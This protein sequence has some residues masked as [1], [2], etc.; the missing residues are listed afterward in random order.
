VLDDVPG[1]LFLLV[2]SGPETMRIRKLIHFLRLDD[3]VRLMG[4]VPYSEV[5]R[6]YPISDIFCI[7]SL[8]EGTCMV[9]EEAAAARLPVVATDFAGANDLIRNGENGF[10]VPVG[11]A[12]AVAERVAW[13]LQHESERIR[14]GEANHRMVEENFSRAAALKKCEEMFRRVTPVPGSAS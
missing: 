10:I 2:G 12:A 13:L 8:Y 14:M 4:G 7:T 11:D 5:K 9:L 1:A 6:Y 3:H